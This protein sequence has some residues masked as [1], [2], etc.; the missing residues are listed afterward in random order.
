[1]QKE[2]LRIGIVFILACLMLTCS[3]ERATVSKTIH[4]HFT[5]TIYFEIDSVTTKFSQANYWKSQED[6]MEYLVLFNSRLPAIQFYNWKTRQLDFK[7]HLAKEGPNGIPNASS[8]FVHT[9]DS[10]FVLSAYQYKF[11]QIN[12][13]GEV[14]NTISLLPDDVV[15]ILKILSQLEP[16]QMLCLP[17]LMPGY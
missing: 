15:L 4:V 5:D 7:I 9:L 1:M 13:A 12:R 6:T 2:M 16:Q 17:C 11:F 3:E 10:I 14:L 8:L